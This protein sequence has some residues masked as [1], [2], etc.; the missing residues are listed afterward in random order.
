MKKILI[1]P[2]IM[3]LGTL[4]VFGQYDL[5]ALQFSQNIYQSDARSTAVGNAIGAVGANYFSSVINPAGLAFFRRGEFLISTA[6]NGINTTSSYLGNQDKSVRNQLSIPSI[7]F[8]FPT[9]N[10]INGKE[11]TE[12]W[13]SNTFA[14]GLNR[15]NSFLGRSYY[16][17]KNTKSSILDYYVE[18]AEGRAVSQL[19]NVTWLAYETY[20]INPVGGNS[21]ESAMGTA[22]SSY[23]VTQAKSFASRGAAYDMNFA[24]AGNYSNMIYFGAKV[25][26]PF[27]DNVTTFSFNEVN[28]NPGSNYLASEYES[29]S[30]ISAVGF[31]AGIGVI[32]KP[33]KFLRIGGSI[34]TPTFLRVNESYY[35]Q[36]SSELDTMSIEPESIEG[37]FNFNATTPFKATASVAIIAGKNGF[38]SLDYEYLDYS[39]AILSSDDYPFSYENK[40][41]TD[42]YTAVNNIRVG[43]EYKIGIFAFRGGYA[44]YESPYQEQFKPEKGDRSYKVY[45]LGLG[46]REKA[47]YVDLTWQRFM[48]NEFEI[49]Y[50]L[51]S[52]EVDPATKE[53]TGTNLIMTV[54]FRF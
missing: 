13:V 17:G 3:V 28:K 10:K 4:G 51:S 53:M 11:V 38:I 25:G 43:G 35:E 6:F 29:E 36:I 16:A 18:S 44:L 46:L 30:D 50:I 26:I 21:Y 48:T 47:Y 52:D 14:F 40:N 1:I 27:I 5:Q 9:I 23:N 15:T 33:V 34:I 39:T 31:N 22:D 42:Y 12:G 41:I 8:V 19:P 7:A 54:G 20:L 32:I 37:K 24:F 49:P 45:S 2:V